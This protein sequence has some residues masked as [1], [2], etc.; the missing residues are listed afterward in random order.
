MSHTQFLLA[1]GPHVI[2]RL[3]WGT[4]KLSSEMMGGQLLSAITV[5]M[6]LA[7]CPLPQ[8][9]GPLRC[10]LR[11][12]GARMLTAKCHYFYTLQA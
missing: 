12:S 2:L 1:T 3:D 11:G 10:A 5:L 8:R 4:L 6:L 9:D 7:V